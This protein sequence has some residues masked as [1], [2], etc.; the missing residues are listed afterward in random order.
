[1]SIAS[2]AG[3]AKLAPLPGS[4][5]ASIQPGA[6]AIAK[7]SFVPSYRVKPA[8][9]GAGAGDVGRLEAGFTPQADT[10][11]AATRRPPSARKRSDLRLGTPPWNRSVVRRCARRNP[12]GAVHLSGHAHCRV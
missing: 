4:L 1:M 7:P 5:L 2:P 3:P 11:S 6:S 9:T 8:G 10:T 12:A